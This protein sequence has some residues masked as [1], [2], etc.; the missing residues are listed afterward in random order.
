MPL[1]SIR[2]GRESP[3]R[4]TATRQ[5]HANAATHTFPAFF[6][7]PG[8]PLLPCLP[9]TRR[10]LTSFWA[11]PESADARVAVT[12]PGNT[13]ALLARSLAVPRQTCEHPDFSIGSRAREPSRPRKFFVCAGRRRR[14]VQDATTRGIWCAPG[15]DDVLRRTS[16]PP[17][18]SRATT[19]CVWFFWRALLRKIARRSVAG[20]V[21][22]SFAP[23]CT[24]PAEPRHRSQRRHEAIPVLV[25]APCCWRR[26]GELDGEGSGAMFAH[27][28]Q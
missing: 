20:G 28:S 11:S 25:L 4:S 2:V 12:S 24:A 7:P 14:F 16:G 19:L 17:Q 6:L 23:H 10:P 1:S 8:R 13:S 26:L 9:G 22:G 3:I 18:G 27:Y 5:R 21:L 15:R